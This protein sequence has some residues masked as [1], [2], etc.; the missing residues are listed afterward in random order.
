M[1]DADLIG[2][3]DRRVTKLKS[4]HP[5]ATGRA[6]S[7]DIGHLQ[8]L[9]SKKPTAAFDDNTGP[10]PP[11]LAQPSPSKKNHPVGVGAVVSGNGLI[12]YIPQSRPAVQKLASK[13]EQGPN[14]RLP[15]IALEI[16]Q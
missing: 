9:T 2:V 7:F 11:R 13:S 15:D 4:R 10:P 14:K 12:H 6:E 1:P 3:I 5:T 16:F 8:Y